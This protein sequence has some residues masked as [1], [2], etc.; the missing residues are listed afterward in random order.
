MPNFFPGFAW[1]PFVILVLFK[2]HQSQGLP[3]GTD[4]AQGHTG[5]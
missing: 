5:D 2:A 4:L 3:P 1:F